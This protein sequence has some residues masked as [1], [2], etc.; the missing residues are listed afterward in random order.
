MGMKT[1]HLGGWLA[2]VLP[3]ATLLLLI[4]VPWNMKKARFCVSN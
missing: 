1:T 4:R 3:I 2:T